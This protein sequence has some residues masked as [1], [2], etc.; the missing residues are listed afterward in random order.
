MQYFKLRWGQKAMSAAA[1]TERCSWEGEEAEFIS[2][3]EIASVLPAL[4]G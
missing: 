3:V 1:A 2:F 4:G